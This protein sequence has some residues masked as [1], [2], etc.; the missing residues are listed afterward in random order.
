MKTKVKKKEA[1]H[2][3]DQCTYPPVNPLLVSVVAQYPSAS[4]WLRQAVLS[5]SARN[6]VDAINDA[7]ALLRIVKGHP[8]VPSVPESA[9]THLPLMVESNA[10]TGEIRI[11]GVR[12]NGAV[13]YAL[14]GHFKGHEFRKVAACATKAVEHLVECCYKPDDSPR[15]EPLDLVDEVTC[16]ECGSSCD[17][18]KAIKGML[19]C[20][21]CGK[22]SEL[23]PEETLMEL[24]ARMG[25]VGHTENNNAPFL[26]SAD[27]EYIWFMTEEVFRQFNLKDGDNVIFRGIRGGN[28][29][30]QQKV[31]G[32]KLKPRIGMI[33]QETVGAQRV[34]IYDDAEN[35]RWYVEPDDVQGFM[36]NLGD[37]VVFRGRKCHRVEIVNNLG[38]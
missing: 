5:M 31:E 18:R 34:Y 35:Y 14:L 16:P 23:A 20:W 36:L 21:D 1:K 13:T 28:V 9:Q 11:E 2:I 38:H 6:P 12:L 17:P 15:T 7:E 4:L 29:I 10:H 33:M 3:D 24:P 26:K 32:P 27:E 19:Q 30:I 8:A 22:S 37:F 25:I